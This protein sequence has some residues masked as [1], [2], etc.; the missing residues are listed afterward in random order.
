MAERGKNSVSEW[1]FSF[2]NFFEDMGK[3]PE[4][5]S[6]LIAMTTNTLRTR[7]LLLVGPRHRATKTTPRRW[8][9]NH[10]TDLQSSTRSRSNLTRNCER[11]VGE[12]HKKDRKMIEKVVAQWLRSTKSVVIVAN[13][14]T[15]KDRYKRCFLR[16][17]AGVGMWST[18]KRVRYWMLHH[19]T[20]CDCYYFDLLLSME[21]S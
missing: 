7:Q 6:K 1:K 21:E 11:A 13:G 2:Q 12:L 8:V 17:G 20:H 15:L 4:K 3:R 18:T 19:C 9:S 14:A 10:S 16:Y 5:D